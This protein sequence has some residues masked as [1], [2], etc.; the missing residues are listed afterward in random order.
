MKNIKIIFL[1]DPKPD[2]DAVK[3]A[4]NKKI[5][6]FDK[7]EETLLNNKVDGIVLCTPNTLHMKQTIFCAKIGVHVYCEKPLSLLPGEVKKMS[8]L[9]CGIQILAA[10]NKAA[11][12]I[13]MISKYVSSNKS[14]SPL[15]SNC[16]TSPCAIL[17]EVEDNNFNIS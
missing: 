9:P 14:I 10:A 16:K 8:Q 15:Y 1:I 11:V 17:D 6:I 4:A 2:S 3:L 13:F 5:P 12:F 7:F